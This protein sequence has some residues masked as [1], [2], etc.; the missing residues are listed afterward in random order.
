MLVIDWI[1]LSSSSRFSVIISSLAEVT[2][3][4]HNTWGVKVAD[5]V[6]ALALVVK[7]AAAWVRVP[8]PAATK[9]DVGK[10]PSTEGAPMIQNR[11]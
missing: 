5:A 4:K 3:I 10:A 1:P 11:T 6:K 2:C 8:T 7:I 9:M